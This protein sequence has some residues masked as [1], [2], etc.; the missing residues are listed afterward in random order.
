M[1]IEKVTVD[2]DKLNDDA[3][4]YFPYRWAT[5]SFYSTPADAALITMNGIK[6][7]DKTTVLLSRSYAVCTFRCS[8]EVSCSQSPFIGGR[9]Y[10]QTGMQTA[11]IQNSV[12]DS[13]RKDDS[14]W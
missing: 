9:I 7:K 2:L 14:A 1:A 6:K 4:K 13:G 10:L 12:G 8:I 5:R 3:P 11:P